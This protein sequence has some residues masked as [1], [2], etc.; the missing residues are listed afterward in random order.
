MW[1][2]IAIAVMLV[3]SVFLIVWSAFAAGSREDDAVERWLSNRE[4]DEH[5]GA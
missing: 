2:W 1:V 4:D 5:D 3:I